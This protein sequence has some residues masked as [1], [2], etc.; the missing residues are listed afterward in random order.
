MNDN[1]N[2]RPSTS[3]TGRSSLVPRQIQ[4]AESTQNYDKA[5]CDHF[6]TFLSVEK[7]LPSI[8]KLTYEDVEEENAVIILTDFLDWLQTNPY[9]NRNTTEPRPLAEGSA[10]GYFC[11]VRV[12]LS[13]T[14]P[15]HPWLKE[16]EVEHMSW[17]KDLVASFTS[18]LR[19]TQHNMEEPIDDKTF[20]L[21]RDLRNRTYRP[22]TIGSTSKD[23]TTSNIDLTFIQRQLFQNPS[24]SHYNKM[25]YIATTYHADGR[26]GEVKFL[27]WN[28][29]RYDPFLRCTVGLWREAKTLMR[30]A[31]CFVHMRYGPETYLTDFY[32]CMFL[33][34]VMADGLIRPANAFENR[35]SGADCTF[36]ELQKKK[37]DAV[38]KV[39][40]STIR[41]SI[42]KDLQK[43]YSAKSLRYGATTTLR[44]HRDINDTEETNRSGHASGSNSDRYVDRNNPM[45]TLPGGLGLCEY[46]DC[47]MAPAAPTFFSLG[48]ENVEVFNKFI[49]KLVHYDP[50]FTNLFGREGKLRPMIEEVVASA[51]MY[52]NDIRV[53]HPSHEIIHKLVTVGND[54]DI[55]RN[56]MSAMQQLVAWSTKLKESFVTASL[57]EDGSNHQM[58]LSALQSLQLSVATCTHQLDRCVQENILTTNTIITT[59]QVMST[60]Q[61]VA[62]PVATGVSTAS[63]T[64]QRPRSLVATLAEASQLTGGGVANVPQADV[65]SISQCLLY[66]HGKGSFRN[67]RSKEA[68]KAWEVP[69]TSR[70]SKKKVERGLEFISLCMTDEDF[71]ILKQTQD[72]SSLLKQRV[73]GIQE[74]VMVEYRNVLNLDTSAKGRSKNTVSGIGNQISLDMSKKNMSRSS[75]ATWLKKMKEAQEEPQ[76]DAEE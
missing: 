6:N 24:P 41:R 69:N 36:F 38:T 15:S 35:G 68:I 22:L 16:P 71:N 17:W 57:V 73:L 72:Q 75:V 4:N 53:D 39:L 55:G 31:M 37:K 40:T 7:K 12:I 46:Q 74:L 49:D 48:P 19:R 18:S 44:I 32:F 26:G 58:V 10:K 51:I 3:P 1:S 5:A 47:H 67:V 66:F 11:R 70:G 30:Y 33:H 34:I 21:Y 65:K 62:L 50:H 28:E 8:D 63:V 76:E 61:Q 23:A 27:K 14:F 45:N 29:F 56:E 9:L 20:P 60:P 59:P 2:S 42:P 54:C 52:F 64:V 43:H 25:S 13:K